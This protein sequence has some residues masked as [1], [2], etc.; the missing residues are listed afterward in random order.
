LREVLV[1]VSGITSYQIYLQMERVLREDA[2]VQ[3]FSLSEI[4]PTLFSWRVMIT[5]ETARLAD[6][7]RSSDFGGLKAR[8]V[9]NAE[10]LEVVLSR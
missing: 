1:A 5:G 3:Q 8:V 4:E 7:L 6:R 10:R 2:E 9:V